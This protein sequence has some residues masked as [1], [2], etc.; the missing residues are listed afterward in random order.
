V[1]PSDP[2]SQQEEAKSQKAE[3]YDKG[4]RGP[5]E[6]EDRR[7]VVVSLIGKGPAVPLVPL[8]AE[9]AVHVDVNQLSAGDLSH[10]GRR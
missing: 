8:V 1:E 4:K 9:T 2:R 10:R 3:A 7:G 5:G 6:E